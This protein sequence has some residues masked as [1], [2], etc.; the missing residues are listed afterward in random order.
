MYT[1]YWLF[2]TCKLLMIPWGLFSKLHFGKNYGSEPQRLSHQKGHS[3]YAWFQ[4]TH[5]FKLW[6]ESLHF[7][8]DITNQDYYALYS[9]FYPTKKMPFLPEEAACIRWHQTRDGCFL[10]FTRLSDAL[11]PHLLYHIRLHA[12]EKQHWKLI[13]KPTVFS[14]ALFS[15]KRRNAWP[16]ALTHMLLFGTV[17]IG[18]CSAVIGLA[19]SPTAPTLLHPL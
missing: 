9:W 18:W 15:N 7:L 4:Q 8:G 12:T 5:L 6:L 16:T 10:R 1:S 19:W 3:S 11:C 14:V 17:Q 13:R 2:L